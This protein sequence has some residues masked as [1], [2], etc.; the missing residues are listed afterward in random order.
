MRHAFVRAFAL[1]AAVALSAAP[2]HAQQNTSVVEDGRQVSIEYSIALDDGSTPISNVD[3]EPY[4]YRQGEGALF[5]KLEAALA[6]LEVGDTMELT[7]APEDG[8]GA[9]DPEAY[10]A[11]GAAL[12]P[13]EAREEGKRLMLQD[14]SSGRRQLVRVHEVREDQVVLDFNHP[15]AGERLHFTVEIVDV[16]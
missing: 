16:R 3:Q 2:V 5:P 1:A 14:P 11:V 8:F 15:L 4:T 13:E 10:R 12:I 6:G 7:L 9:V